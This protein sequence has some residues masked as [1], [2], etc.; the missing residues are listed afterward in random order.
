LLKRLLR[1]NVNTSDFQKPSVLIL[2]LANL[3]PIFGVVFLGWKVFPILFLYWAENVIVGL[4][5][6]VKMAWASPANG[7][8]IVAKLAII[9]FFCFHYGLFTFVHGVFVVLVF[10]GL[11]GE[12]GEPDLS[13]ILS[14]LVNTGIILGIITLFISHGLSFG[15][16]YLGKKE[17]NEVKLNTLMSQPYG[18]VVVLHV[19]IIFGGFLIAFLGSPEIGLVLLVVLKL[20]IDILAHLRQHARGSA[21]LIKSNVSE[22]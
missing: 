8:S 20:G 17:Y 4:F 11:E 13:F 3:L 19:I 10:G 1:F 6:V 21:S 15:I 2:V 18:R 22:G 5:N 9:P 12:I 14:S 7:N 16:N